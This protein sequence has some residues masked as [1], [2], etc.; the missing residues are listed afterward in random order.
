MLVRLL[1]SEDNSLLSKTSVFVQVLMLFVLSLRLLGAVIKSGTT[2][3]SRV[4]GLDDSQQSRRITAFGSATFAE[5]FQ[6]SASKLGGA[7]MAAIGV[8]AKS[9]LS[10]TQT[11]RNKL[12]FCFIRKPCPLSTANRR[13]QR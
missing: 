5:E 1:L 11:E 12:S 9:A 6:K 3:S 7:E 4:V 10:I 13:S 2:K 8:S